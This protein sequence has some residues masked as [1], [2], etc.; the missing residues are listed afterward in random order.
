MELHSIHGTWELKGVVKIYLAVNGL[1]LGH[2]VRCRMLAEKLSMMGA[3]VLYSTYLDGLEFARRKKL[4]TV[5]AI[6]VFY[7]VRPDGSVDLRAT[8]ARSG[9]SLGLNRFLHQLVQEIRDIKRY[10]PD[11]VLID[12]RLS[13][14]FAARLLGKRTILILNQYR[15]RL[16]HNGDHRSR[17]L[18]DRLFLLIARLGWTFFGTLIGEMWGLSERI[19]IPDFPPPLTISTYNIVIPKRYMRKVSFV[20]PIVD[21]QLYS[22]RPKQ[23]LKRKYGFEPDEMLVYVAISGP[24]HEREPLVRELIP[25]LNNLAE[26]FN[27]VV[28]QGNPMGDDL[29]NRYG[30]MCVY[31]WAENQDELLHACDVLVARAGQS[32]ILKAMILGRPL[33]IIPTPF[34]TE[35]LGN[36]ERARS[37]GA[38]LVLEQEKLSSESLKESL[39]LAMTNPSCLERASHIAS[40]VRNVVGVEECVRIVDQL[41][42]R[43][44]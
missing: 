26:T 1:G 43:R 8:S 15:I 30:R 7:Q 18:A 4:K 20:G 40:Q 25:I 9:F 10:S 16:L 17:G 32:T 22:D 41:V 33:I 37:I 38:A 5:R 36:A 35:Q 13:S 28:S 34:Q 11:V 27:I 42:T 31:D 19:V 21:N 39:N 3:D 2:I 44:S 23:P 12:T 14:L 6:P 29:P 24:K